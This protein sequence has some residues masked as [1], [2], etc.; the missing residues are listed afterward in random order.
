MIS[1][2]VSG[3]HRQ[4]M[5]FLTRMK[6]GRHLEIAAKYGA[7]GVAALQAGTPVEDGETQAGWYYEVDRRPGYLGVHWYNSNMEDPGRIPV[8]VLIQYGHATGN[9]GYVEGR[10]YINPAMRPLFDQIAAEMWKEVTK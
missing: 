6:S 3:T 10:D 5:D 4:T 1:F 7:Q 2:S 8:A 9:G